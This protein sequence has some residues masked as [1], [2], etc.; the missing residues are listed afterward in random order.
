[1]QGEH[2]NW[3]SQVVR[4]VTDKL[5]AFQNSFVLVLELHKKP[6]YISLKELFESL[7]SELSS[8]YSLSVKF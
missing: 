2:A 4:S 5:I 3:I 7:I 6:S 8:L 1:M